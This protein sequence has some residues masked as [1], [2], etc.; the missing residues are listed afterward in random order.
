MEVKSL[1]GDIKN[2]SI[3]R[4]LPL[5]SNFHIIS[6]DLRRVVG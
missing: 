5:S 2:V 6:S 4:S 1:A 3:I